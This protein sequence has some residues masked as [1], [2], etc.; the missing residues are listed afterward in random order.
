MTTSA[1]NG[2]KNGQ[3]GLMSVFHATPWL[4]L[5]RERARRPAIRG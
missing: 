2:R 3:S 1:R 5:I 4:K